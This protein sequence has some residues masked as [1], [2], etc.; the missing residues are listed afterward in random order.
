MRT[1]GGLLYRRNAG[2]Q[3][4]VFAHDVAGVQFDTCV[5][6]PAAEC[7]A[8]SNSEIGFREFRRKSTAGDDGV[9]A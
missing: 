5:G 1:G 4:E 7:T 3:H 6:L 8:L 9:N 2:I